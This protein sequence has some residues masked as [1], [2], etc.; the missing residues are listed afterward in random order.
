[1]PAS[2][3]AASAGLAAWDV[4]ARHLV[5]DDPAAAAAVL[6]D[7][8]ATTAREHAIRLVILERLGDL[9]GLERAAGPAAAVLLDPAARAD[10]AVLVR[11]RPLVAAALVGACAPLLPALVDV[12]SGLRAHLGDGEVRRAALAGLHALAPAAPTGPEDHAALARLL[13]LR[14][15]LAASEGRSAPAIRDLEAALE[16][17][18]PDLD[19]DEELAEI[20]APRSRACWPRSRR[21]R[22][23]CTRR[24]PFAAASRPSG[25]AS[26]CSQSRRSRACLPTTRR[27]AGTWPHSSR[28]H[29]PGCVA[30]SGEAPAD[31]AADRRT[32]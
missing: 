2:P 31:P 11:T 15:L 32:R 10:L 27:E 9:A 3:S 14:G 1:M 8:P 17:V 5:D 19:E 6:S 12:W 22:P 20:H 18:S 16:R 13:A 29:L 25:P 30:R 23:G 24:L 26:A 21:R 7:M 28:R 4:A